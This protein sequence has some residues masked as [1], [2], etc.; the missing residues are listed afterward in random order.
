LDCM[1]LPPA[2]LKSLVNVPGF[3]E[4]HFVNAHAAAAPV[5]IRLNPFKP[6][7]VF[8]D[9]LQVPWC[10]QAR[11]LEERPSFTLDPLF[12]AGCYYVQE[13]SSMFI[14]EVLRQHTDLSK[15]LRVLDLC[16]APGGKSTHLASLL[17]HHAL[18]VANE[19]IR[20]RVNTLAGNLTKWGTANSITTN[21]DP[22]DFKELE[23]YFDVIVVDAPCSGSGLFRKD[24]QAITEW[25]IENVQ[26]CAGRQERILADVM[27][28]LKEGGLL[29]YSTCSYSEEENEGTA[30]A[31]MNMGPF[32]S[33]DVAIGN[34]TGIIRT[35]SANH[36]AHG[37][38]FYPDKV[39]GEGFYAAAFRK[40]G[41]VQAV[42]MKTG[43]L[44]KTTSAETAVLHKWVRTT[45]DLLFFVHSG[46][47]R[48]IH[49]QHEKD[50]L[51]L[52]QHL[53]IKNA[54]T[55]AGA[56]MKG[57][58]IPDHALA[59]STWLDKGITTVNVDKLTAL[60]YLKR[61]EIKLPGAEPGWVLVCFEGHGLGWAKAL[62]NRV[63]NYYPKEWRILMDIPS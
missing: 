45:G 63:N 1:R 51:F 46:N 25:S 26:V 9:A 11:Y 12:H 39:K 57:D 62:P 54:G 36:W 30:D 61:E 19:V 15:P 42:R 53:Y 23:G 13:P 14:G 38:R 20:S 21:N 29:I 43:A 49:G 24:P 3:N 7:P 52:Q 18:L 28:A 60:K 22:A 58:L 17:S 33:L 35:R 34:A 59:L 44:K 48:F 50:L 16:A 37:F 47:I 27:P 55:T 6:A 40:T 8:K 31:I 4:D 56:I 10:P 5:T 2:L 32:D 41:S